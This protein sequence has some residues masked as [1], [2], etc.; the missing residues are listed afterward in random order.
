ME[1]LLKV[2]ACKSAS[3]HSDVPLRVVSVSNFYPDYPEELSRKFEI[4]VKR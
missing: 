2:A 1:A 3:H 4:T